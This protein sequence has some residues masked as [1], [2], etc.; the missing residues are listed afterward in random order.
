VETFEK[1]K[2]EKN[3]CKKRTGDLKKAR[4]SQPTKGVLLVNVQ[5]CVGAELRVQRES[6]GHCKRSG[7]KG[8]V[9]EGNSYPECSGT[10]DLQ[11]GEFVN[12]SSAKVKGKEVG[13]EKKNSLT[14]W[15]HR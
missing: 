13:A 11:E 9:T 2:A 1:K 6:G 10:I 15:L 3:T 7:T 12:K 8:G 14:E 5:L 4:Y